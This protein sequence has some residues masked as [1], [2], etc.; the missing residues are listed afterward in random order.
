MEKDIVGV[1]KLS[2]P[3]RWGLRC[4]M[5]ISGPKPQAKHGVTLLPGTLS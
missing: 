1:Q 5:A 2:R 3:A 4:G